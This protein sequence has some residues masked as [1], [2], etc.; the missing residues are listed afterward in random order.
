MSIF[1]APYFQDH[2]QVT[3]FQDRETGL[4]A[5]I[6]IHDT[7]LGPAGGGCLM[8]PYKSDDDALTDALRRIWSGLGEG[9]E[10]TPPDV[11]DPQLLERLKSLGY[12]GD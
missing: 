12:I 2:E 9:A 7:T 6:A 3:H 11:V 5:I 8:Y 10:L 4:R 1:S